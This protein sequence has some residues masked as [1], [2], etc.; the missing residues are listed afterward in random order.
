MLKNNKKIQIKDLI[1]VGIYT[2]LYFVVVAI[3]A[4]I[5]VFILPG[6]SYVF[7]P[8]ISALFAGTIF[9]L[10][11]AKVPRFGSITIMGSI[12]GLFF[13]LMGRFPGALLISIL[14]ALLAD[15]IALFV[16]YKSKIGLLI[17][18]IVFS[19]SLIGPVL[20]MFIFP[21][22]YIEQLL[23][24]RR[25][26]AYI[27][28]AFANISINTFMVLIFAIL[29]AAIIGGIFGQRMMKKHFEKAGIV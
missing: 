10:M 23:E 16:K 17:S 7:I 25:D 2:V 28:G 1:S 21:S 20:P 22:L 8:V 18:Y 14:F 26:A 27:E 11:V 3:S 5:T 9:M 6:Y 29:I 15:G 24:Q 4:L 13:L 12:M 19:Y